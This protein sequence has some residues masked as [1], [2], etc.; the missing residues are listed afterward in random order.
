[1]DTDAFPT[2]FISTVRKTIRARHLPPA[3]EENY[4]HW[5]EAFIRYGDYTSAEEIRAEDVNRF[6]THLATKP[7]ISPGMRSRAFNA[8]LFLFWHVLRPPPENANPDLGRMR[9]G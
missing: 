6:L 3:T 8:L 4:C 5:I 9:A 1:M 2:S 7:E